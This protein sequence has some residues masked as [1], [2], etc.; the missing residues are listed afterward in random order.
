MLEPDNEPYPQGGNLEPGAANFTKK[1]PG[2]ASQTIIV[3]LTKYSEDAIMLT[4]ISQISPV[5][6]LNRL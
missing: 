5:P 6:S 3:Y 2:S 4:D 1:S